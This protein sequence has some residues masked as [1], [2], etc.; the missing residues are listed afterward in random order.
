[1][2]ASN[3]ELIGVAV[4]II[5]ETGV[6]IWNLRKLYTQYSQAASGDERSLSRK[7]L[8]AEM[9]TEISRRLFGAVGGASLGVGLTAAGTPALTSVMG[10]V[11][12]PGLGSVAGAILGIIGG[13]AGMV[14]CTAL[15]LAIGQWLGKA[16]VRTI[17]V[18]DRALNLKDIEPGDH[19]VLYG[20]QLHPRCHAIAMSIGEDPMQIIIIR[21]THKY[22]VVMETVPFKSPVYRMFY[23]RSIPKYSADEIMQRAANALAEYTPKY[24]ILFYNCKDFVYGITIKSDS[25]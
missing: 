3:A 4:I 2:V 18:N 17:K 7:D 21:H 15:G 13:S 5:C 1:M 8:V 12:C 22:G 6:C 16:I 14:L 10:T 9:V 19:I 25:N 24:N 23:P 20:N 11:F